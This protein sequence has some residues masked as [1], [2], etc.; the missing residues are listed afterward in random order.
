MTSN[1][2][3]VLAP[4]PVP[5]C[6]SPDTKAWSFDAKRRRHWVECGKCNFKTPQMPSK[7]KV[8]A[9]WNTRSQP[10][11]DAMRLAV[12][13]ECARV[14]DRYANRD[15]GRHIAEAIRALAD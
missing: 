6:G 15:T 4:C 7:A 11:P 8:V 1:D 10:T 3:D 9:I 5:W 13:E 2:A 12:I 14:A